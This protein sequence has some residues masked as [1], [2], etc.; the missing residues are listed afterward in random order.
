MKTPVHPELIADIEAFCA[1]R[2]M[3]ETRFGSESIGDPSLL[4]RLRTG[5]ELR[6]ATLKRVRDFMVARRS[7]VAAE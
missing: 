6:V 1:S 4:A 5:R 7:Q 3:A 2:G